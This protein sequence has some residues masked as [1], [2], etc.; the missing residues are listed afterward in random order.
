MNGAMEIADNELAEEIDLQLESIGTQLAQIFEQVTNH[1]AI[2][3]K[4]TNDMNK[5]SNFLQSWAKVLGGTTAATM[6]R[7]TLRDD[8]EEPM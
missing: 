8:G 1:N 4:M 3:T 2:V 5:Y 6:K 7:A